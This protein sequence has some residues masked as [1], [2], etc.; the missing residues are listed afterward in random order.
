V[1]KKTH[2][3][4]EI[5]KKKLGRKNKTKKRLKLK[6][7]KKGIHGKKHSNVYIYP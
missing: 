5:G 4:K 2:E 7:Q 6:C 3:L 1:F